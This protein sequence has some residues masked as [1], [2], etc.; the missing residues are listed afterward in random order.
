MHCVPS[1][2]RILIS[3]GALGWRRKCK[4]PHPSPKNEPLPTLHCKKKGENVFWP[5]SKRTGHTKADKS[6]TI[7]PI[8]E[9]PPFVP[10][11]HSSIHTHRVCLTQGEHFAQ[12]WEAPMY[13][14]AQ[15]NITVIL[16]S[17]ASTTSTKAINHTI[18]RFTDRRPGP[19]RHQPSQEVLSLLTNFQ[20]DWNP[21]PWC[22]EQPVCWFLAAVS[23]VH[24]DSLRIP[25]N[26]MGFLK[27]CGIFVFVF[28]ILSVF[29]LVFLFPSLW[30]VF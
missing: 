9:N 6:G 21:G 3:P 11:S 8:I 15:C 12:G 16:W 4:R 22:L 23:G 14:L 10:T 2:L 19:Q 24:Q 25:Q 29:V 1:R 7:P 26:F 17:G 27:F 28:T 5:G 30:I 18:W 13:L 20:W